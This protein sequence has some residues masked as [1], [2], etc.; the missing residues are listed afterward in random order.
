MLDKPYV[1]T[2]SVRWMQSAVAAL[3]GGLAVA[4]WQHVPDAIGDPK[5]TTHIAIPGALFDIARSV[6][7]NNGGYR[8]VVIERASNAFTFRCQ[9]GMTLRDAI[10]R[11]KQ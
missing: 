9:D 6:C 8:D 7:R 2:R 4:L 10:V 5:P 11:V 3:L 1:V